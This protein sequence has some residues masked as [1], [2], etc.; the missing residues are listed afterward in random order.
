MKKN[1]VIVGAGIGGLATALSLEKSCLPKENLICDL[2]S[3][4]GGRLNSVESLDLGA[5]R[6][7]F[8]KHR[9]LKELI[10]QFSI[11][12]S[13]FHYNLKHTSPNRDENLLQ[14]ERIRRLNHNIETNKININSSAHFYEICSKFLSQDDVNS[15][16]SW[17][18]YDS[19]KHQE[20]PLYVGLSILNGHPESE[21]LHQRE[22]NQW[23]RLKNG[24][25]HLSTEIKKSLINS[26]FE[27]RMAKKLTSI[28]RMGSQYELIFNSNP[29]DKVLCKQVILALPFS[30]LKKIELEGLNS[31]EYFHSYVDIPLF[32]CFIGFSDLS[33][34]KNVEENECLI[35]HSRL[36]KLYCSMELKQIFFYTDFE[37]AEYWHL[38][39]TVLGNGFM[40]FVLEQIA[41][42]FQL[43]LKNLPRPHYFYHKYWPLG[44][45]FWKKGFASPKSETGYHQL[46]ENIF[47]CSDLFTSSGGWVEGVL[48]SSK[49]I[50]NKI[51]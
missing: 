48:E 26:C 40:D 2:G 34:L 6:F 19:L 36:R 37:S 51:L 18:G 29:L 30:E 10:D 35:T 31:N 50:L 33:W 12:L 15:L 16:C 11:P 42:E 20:M 27:L 17:S 7:H 3:D 23:F 21:W 38:Q 49:A 32:K 5:G 28:R 45:T 24:F 9:L 44:I 8:R 4:V 46:D 25:Q 41:K 22:D 39:S 14:K 1:V 13:P 43:T 47:L